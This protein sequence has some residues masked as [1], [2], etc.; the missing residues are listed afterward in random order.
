MTPEKEA[1]INFIKNCKQLYPEIDMMDEEIRI[2]YETCWRILQ[3]KPQIVKKQPTPPAIPRKKK[4]GKLARYEEDVLECLH[5]GF[6]EEQQ[7]L[8]EAYARKNQFA[9][10]NY[11]KAYYRALGRFQRGE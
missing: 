4:L 2:E 8:D 11:I 5:Q 10:R 3:E 7:L 6:G 1:A 9:R